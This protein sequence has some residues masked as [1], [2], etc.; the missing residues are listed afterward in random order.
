MKLTINGETQ[1][2]DNVTNITDLVSS[3]E[4]DVCKLA[5]ERNLELV[6]KSQ[7]DKVLLADNDN[8]EIVEFIGGG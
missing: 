8:I 3:L 7:Y 5:I 1:V 6:P 2:I 4:L